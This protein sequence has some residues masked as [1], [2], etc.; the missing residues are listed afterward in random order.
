METRWSQHEESV[1]LRA[2]KRAIKRQGGAWL[3]HTKLVVGPV[4]ADQDSGVA[5]AIAVAV[6]RRVF[7]WADVL[8]AVSGEQPHE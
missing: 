7:Q 3:E 6:R 5:P 2:G 4:L 1:G 8:L